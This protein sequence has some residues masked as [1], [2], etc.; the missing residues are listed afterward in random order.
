MSVGSCCTATTISILVNF[1]QDAST[2]PWPSSRPRAILLA[3][4][5]GVAVTEVAVT[6]PA[7]SAAILA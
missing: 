5:A 6:L 1:S 4:D 3:T 2:V 7:H